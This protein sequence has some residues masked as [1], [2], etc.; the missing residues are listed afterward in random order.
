[1]TS[2]G[3]DMFVSNF[4]SALE[5]VAS[6]SRTY[7]FFVIFFGIL[8]LIGIAFGIHALFIAGTRHAYGTNREI[9]VAILISTYVFFVVAS[10]GFVWSLPWDMS[11]A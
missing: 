7:L 3:K 1:M 11:S 9:P 4:K 2:S 8:M 10:R 5:R 6:G